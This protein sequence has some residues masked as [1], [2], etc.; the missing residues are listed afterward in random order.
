MELY[1]IFNINIWKTDYTIFFAIMFAFV[2]S[3]S[4]DNTL[5]Y[6]Q[7]VMTATEE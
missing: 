7:L 2:P 3:G 5:H 4:D 6:V 1:V